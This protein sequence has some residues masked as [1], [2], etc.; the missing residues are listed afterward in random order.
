MVTTQDPGLAIRF[1]AWLARTATAYHLWCAELELRLT[2]TGAMPS[3]LRK[4]RARN[5]DLLRDY[6]GRGEFPRNSHDASRN[7]P[8]FI[9]AEGRQCAVACLMYASGDE[10]SALKVAQSANS[11]RIRQ[12]QFPELD[13]WADESGFTKAELARIQPPRY[14]PT[15]DELN[16]AYDFLFALWLV[17]SLAV[18]S[19]LAN[20]LRLMNAFAHRFDTSLIGI[21]GTHPGRHK[22]GVQCR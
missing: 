3:A 12:M 20:S 4:V 8:C 10:A 15:P 2:D 11:A 5:L 6:R 13:T 21:P 19:I 22:R 17:G 1:C 16:H 18:T 9:D 7:A 14:A